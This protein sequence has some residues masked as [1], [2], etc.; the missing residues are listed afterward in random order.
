MEML[1]MQLL[2]STFWVRWNNELVLPNRKL[3]ERIY[4][5]TDGADKWHSKSG[6]DGEYNNISV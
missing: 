4:L 5:E 1:Q 6:T 2:D 3:N